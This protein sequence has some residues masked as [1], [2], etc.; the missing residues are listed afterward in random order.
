MHDRIRGVIAD[1]F[2]LPPD[3]VGSDADAATLEGWDSL[4]HLELMLAL[5]MEFGVQISSEEM[6][7]LLSVAAIEECL[8]GQGASV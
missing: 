2:G 7:L 3:A 1:V 4:R 8:R 5:E 6:P